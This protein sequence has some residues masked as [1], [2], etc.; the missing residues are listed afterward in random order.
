MPEDPFTFHLR[1]RV[2][3]G[4]GSIEQVGILAR[5]QGFRRTLLVADP[6]LVG[7]GHVERATRRLERAGISSIPFHDF[8]ANPDSAMIERGRAF[9]APHEVDSILGL[10]GGSS[11]DCAKGISFLL[12][13]GGRMHDYTGFGKAERPLLPML[14]VPTTAGTGSEAQC[15]AVIADAATHMKM[16]CGDPSASF[17]V[18]LLDPELTVSQP[19]RVTATTGFDAIAHAVESFVTSRRSAVSICFAREAWRL[20]TSSYARVLDQPSDRAARSAMLLGAHYA[21]MAIEQSMLG[22]AHACANPL[23]AHH[24]VTHGLALSVLLPHVV[25]WNAPVVGPAYGELLAMAGRPA[26]PDIAGERLAEYILELVRAGDLP[27][28]LAEVH[29]RQPDVAS[30]AAEAAE[31]MTGTCNP[32]P[33]DAAAA[34]AIYR[35]AL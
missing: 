19:A 29:V 11:L 9:A 32:R 25:R 26:A 33:F 27:T 4:H 8:D 2:V 30:L 28:T 20:L 24:G 6:G 1:T 31:Q 35:C 10:G 7:A 17:K 12:T 14:G 5:E 3:F 21:G 18:A 23:T 13:N 15:W 16:A 22:A 34:E